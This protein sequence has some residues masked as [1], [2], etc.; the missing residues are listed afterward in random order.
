MGAGDTLGFHRN[1]FVK[2]ATSAGHQCRRRP[3]CIS[4]H[5]KA[6]RREM[7]LRTE[8]IVP[9]FKGVFTSS[10]ANAKLRVVKGGLDRMAQS[11]QHASSRTFDFLLLQSSAWNFE[12]DLPSHDWH[13]VIVHAMCATD[14][15]TRRC[16]IAAQLAARRSAMEAIFCHFSRQRVGC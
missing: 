14:S 1:R 6:M 16:F 15:H 3:D 11:R 9:C 7:R 13:Y 12:P 4:G 5:N 10:L 8:Q 2:T